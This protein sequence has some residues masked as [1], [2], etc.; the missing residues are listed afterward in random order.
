M[1][2]RYNPEAAAASPGFLVIARGNSAESS[3]IAARFE[4]VLDTQT[5][6][7]LA[8]PA[9]G[10]LY[11]HGG[12][13]GPEPGTTYD[14]FVQFLQELM[15]NRTETLPSV[16]SFSELMPESMIDPAYGRRLCNM[17]TQV[18]TR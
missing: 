14:H 2:E 16:I 3:G 4:T 7:G 17:M 10:M 12:V 5:A 15:T 8:W 6:L 1:L 11:N 18:G 13:F 9:R